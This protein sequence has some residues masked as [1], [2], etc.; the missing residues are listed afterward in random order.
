MQTFPSNSRRIAFGMKYGPQNYKTIID[1]T[2]EIINH[3]LW[4]NSNLKINNKVIHYR[5]WEE[6]GIQWLSDLLFENE[7]LTLRFLSHKE[8]ERNYTTSAQTT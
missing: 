3:N 7:D 4:Y 8:I 5:Q 2:E 6:R 1:Q